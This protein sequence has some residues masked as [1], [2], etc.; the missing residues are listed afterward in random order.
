MNSDNIWIPGPKEDADELRRIQDERERLLF[1][2]LAGAT[3]RRLHI[4]KI[5]PPEV[6]R[7]DTAAELEAELRGELQA[8][9]EEQ[10]NELDRMPGE[11][12]RQHRARLRRAR[13]EA[14]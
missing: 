7:F 1:E 10:P 4:G 11:N 8:A 5:P 3:D 6:R 14:S 12:R 2:Q 13:G 9:A